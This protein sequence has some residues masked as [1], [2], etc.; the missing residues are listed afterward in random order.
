MTLFNTL[1]VTCATLTKQVSNLEQDKIT[2][3]IE[4]IK[5]KQRVR[6]R[7]HPNRGK[8][9]ELDA[10]EDVTLVNAKEDMNADVQGSMQVTDE[11]E[12]AEVEE[13]IEVVIA[14]KLIT[15]VVTT[16]ATTITAA[17]VPKASALRRRRGIVIQDPEETATASVLTRQDS[18]SFRDYQAQ[19]KGREVREE[20]ENLEFRVKEIKEGW[21]KIAEFDADKDVT[22]VDVDAEVKMDANIQGRMAESQAKVYNLDLQH[23]KK[24]LSMQ[25]TDE[26]E[27]AEVEEVLEV[28]TAAKLMTEVK[29]KDKG[30]GILTEEPK[31][32]K[33][34]AQIE[35]DEAFARQ[36]KPELNANI[37][38]NEVIEQVKRKE[39]HD[40]E[41][42]RYQA[43]K[44]KPLTEAQARKNMMIY[45]KNMAGFKMNFFKSMTYSEI[46]PIFEKHYNSIRAFLEKEDE[47]VTVQEKR[48]GE[49]L[50]KETAK[51]QRIDEEAGDLKRHLQIVVNDD[52]D[53]Y[54][55]ATSLASKHPNL[56]LDTIL[57]ELSVTILSTIIGFETLYPKKLCSV[58]ILALPEGSEDF[59]VYCDASHKGLETKDVKNKDVKGMLIENSKDPEKLRMEKLEPRVDGTLCL[60]GRS[61]LPCYGDLRTVAAPFKA[62]YDQKYRSS[63]C[64]AEVGEV[65]LLGLEIFQE[66]IEKIIQIKK[67][68]QAAHDRQK[69]YADL[70][71]KPMEFQVGDRVMLKVG[72]VA[73]K[74]E[75]PQELSTVHNTF[76]V[77][78][79]K[80]CY[81]N[82]PL[83]VLLDGLHFDDKLYF[84]EEP[85]EIMDREVKRLKRSRISIV[86]V[87][88]NSRRGPE[89]T[90]EREDQFRK[91]YPHLFTK[92]APLSSVTS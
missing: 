65:Q 50:E 81:A 42:M 8:I 44:R 79:L 13:V 87:R 67:I 58:P 6:R 56:I 16:A 53:V 3:A 71:R 69:S 84:V 47:E 66:T 41:V 38:W 64:W 82:E 55:E 14:A 32:L 35:Q 5:L 52:D 21:G 26:A 85:V 12:P 60:N 57:V 30:K 54:T 83:A 28:V 31:P 24:V 61:W 89:F 78:N 22:Q 62:L 49:N 45:L 73:Y 29:P 48:Q 11:A 4:I 25:D 51:K 92:D 91:K 72:S 18:S 23:S 43:L 36:L 63:V 10:D 1:L 80:K 88:W 77:S 40:N 39:R 90:W 70:K 34:K 33:K 46:R 7:I 2:Q 86:K 17:Q 59:V 75:L 9:A 27:P 68:I 15:K 19:A 20:E 76:H 74:L 37:N